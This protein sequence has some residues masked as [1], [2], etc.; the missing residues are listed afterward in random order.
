MISELE[1]LL[2]FE[3]KGKKIINVHVKMMNTKIYNVYF[4]GSIIVIT[5]VA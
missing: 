5:L 1:A 4:T 2:T 3:K